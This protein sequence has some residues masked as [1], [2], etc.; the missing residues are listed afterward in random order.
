MDLKQRVHLRRLNKLPVVVEEFVLVAFAPLPDVNFA[1]FVVVR[2]VRVRTG[3][4]LS[5]TFRD[6]AWRVVT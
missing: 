3:F 6:F 2:K 5:A 1:N 4:D